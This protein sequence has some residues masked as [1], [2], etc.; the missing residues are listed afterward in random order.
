M[1]LL[2]TG[3]AL[4][5]WLG[6]CAWLVAILRYRSSMKERDSAQVAVVTEALAVWGICA[7]LV[8]VA[9]LSYAGCVRS[10]PGLKDVSVCRLA[11]IGVMAW[12]LAVAVAL[13]HCARG[14]GVVF[15]AVRGIFGAAQASLRERRDMLLDRFG[16]PWYRP[17]MLLLAVLC[18]LAGGAACYALLAWG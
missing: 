8:G 15:S 3:L 10:S 16:R 18:L 9:C 6:L 4:V 7:V 11:A 1:L 13:V 2:A 17:A 14:G 5:V 12:H